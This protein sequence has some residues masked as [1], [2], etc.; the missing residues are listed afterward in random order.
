MSPVVLHRFTD[1]RKEDEMA[2]KEYRVTLPNGN[3]EVM[4][5][6]SA[7]QAAR[8]AERQYCMGHVVTQRGYVSDR[9]KRHR[10]SSNS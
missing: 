7:E 6:N 1:T 10:S 3:V 2:A 9:L 5:A 8:R 4:M